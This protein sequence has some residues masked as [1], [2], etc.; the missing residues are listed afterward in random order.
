M[1]KKK[2]GNSNTDGFDITPTEPVDGIPVYDDHLLENTL[3]GTNT[4]CHIPSAVTLKSAL[5]EP[6][7][8]FNVSAAKLTFQPVSSIKSK[9]QLE[10]YGKPYDKVKTQ[11]LLCTRVLDS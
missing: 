3:K 1:E 4:V 5:N 10:H 6:K 2:E 9:T 7:R 11:G 8:G